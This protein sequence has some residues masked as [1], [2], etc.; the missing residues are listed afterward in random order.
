MSAYFLHQPSRTKLTLHPTISS[1][2][3]SQQSTPRASYDS[4][5][6]PIISEKQISASEKTEK[7]L[8]KA[9]QQR[10]KEHQESVRGSYEL[11]YGQGTSTG[12]VLGNPFAPKKI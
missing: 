1:K 2:A 5:K 11:L 3:T 10:W 8:I 9:M 4:M 6:S 7:G 12:R